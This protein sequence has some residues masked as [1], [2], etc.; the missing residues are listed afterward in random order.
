MMP[1]I[2]KLLPMTQGSTLK[3]Q[4]NPHIKMTILRVPN[5]WI[6][7]QIITQET[8]GGTPTPKAITSVFVPQRI[9]NG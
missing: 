4:I 8:I 6:Y 5:G 9:Y 3:T 2:D 7:T 1:T